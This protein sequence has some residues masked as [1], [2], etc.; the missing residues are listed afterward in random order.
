MTA[1]DPYRE[2]VPS[3]HQ[4]INITVTRGPARRAD[5]EAPTPGEVA[6]ATSLSLIHAL[7]V[8]LLIVLIA[9]LVLSITGA[10]SVSDLTDRVRDLVGGTNTPA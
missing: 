2:P 6:A 10:V 7:L 1:H 4:D 9:V 3:R 5:L 8:A